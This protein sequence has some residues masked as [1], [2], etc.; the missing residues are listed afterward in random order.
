MFVSE[1]IEK[2]QQYSWNI[3]VRCWND[4]VLHKDFILVE[5][6]KDWTLLVSTDLK[7]WPK[8]KII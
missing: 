8:E 6:E 1:L 4:E 5:N 2:L 7:E 3:Q